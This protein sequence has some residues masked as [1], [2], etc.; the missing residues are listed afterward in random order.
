MTE[1]ASS[2][3]QGIAGALKSAGFARASNRKMHQRCQFA[4]RNCSAVGGIPAHGSKCIFMPGSI[5]GAVPGCHCFASFTFFPFFSLYLPCWAGGSPALPGGCR[6]PALGRCPGRR[7]PGWH[8]LAV[9]TSWKVVPG[10]R[11]YGERKTT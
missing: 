8:L 6:G 10:V 2:T 7:S 5:A 11:C 1:G 3:S 9:G 4:M